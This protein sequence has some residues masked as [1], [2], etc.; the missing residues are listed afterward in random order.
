MTEE[1]IIAVLGQPW[2]ANRLMGDLTG[3]LVYDRDPSLLVYV[4]V[5][6]GCQQVTCF[7]PTAAV[8]DGDLRLEGTFTDV[9]KLLRERGYRVEV[10]MEEP[11]APSEAWCDELGIGLWHQR[12][13]IEHIESVSGYSREDFKRYFEV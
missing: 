11:P 4:H 2:G 6:N 3:R 10:E 7:H 8:V 13:D 12:D 9:V 5:T 1:E